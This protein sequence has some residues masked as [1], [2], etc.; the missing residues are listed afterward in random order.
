[1]VSTP[2]EDGVDG[3]MLLD[4]KVNPG[5]SGGPLC[6]ERGN[7]L[8]IVT[9]KS[10]ISEELHA[11]SYGMARPSWD[12]DAFLHKR[13]RDYKPVAV[14]TKK[15]ASWADVDRLVSPSVVLIMRRPAEEKPKE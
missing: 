5:N 11:D 1:V 2:P 13:F 6:D 8:G 14:R 15:L 3:M 10:L 4:A 12:I 9:A 7:V